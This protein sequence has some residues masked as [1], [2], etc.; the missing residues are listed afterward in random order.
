MNTRRFVMLVMVGCMALIATACGG[1]NA[2]TY[3]QADCA[4]AQLT[5]KVTATWHNNG[6]TLAPKKSR[7]S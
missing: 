1:N 5:I 6:A 3:R 4:K 2:V 7:S